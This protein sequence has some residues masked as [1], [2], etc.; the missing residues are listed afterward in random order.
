MTDFTETY[1]MKDLKIWYCMF[2][3]TIC[4]LTSNMLSNAALYNSTI[5][6]AIIELLHWH[7]H[8]SI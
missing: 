3:P 7:G 1:R 2:P 5:T 4:F 6:L 8:I